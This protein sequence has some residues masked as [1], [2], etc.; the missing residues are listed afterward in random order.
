MLLNSKQ[1]KVY[2]NLNFMLIT[3]YLS[4]LNK[5]KEVNL[6]IQLVYLDCI[7]LIVIFINLIRWVNIN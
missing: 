4:Y 2:Y 3:G 7:K 1:Y 5:H 6:Y